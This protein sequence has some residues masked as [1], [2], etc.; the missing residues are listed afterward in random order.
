MYTA[1][2]IIS[3][4][5]VNG[6]GQEHDDPCIIQRG[7]LFNHIDSMQNCPSAAWFNHSHGQYLVDFFSR[8]KLSAFCQDRGRCLL[9]ALNFDAQSFRY[10]ILCHHESLRNCF[11]SKKYIDV[12]YDEY[13]MTSKYAN[14]H[15]TQ[16]TMHQS[17]RQ[18]VNTG[19]D[20]NK[21][22]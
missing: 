1:V 6:V 14:I 4:L 19:R 13:N 8:A 16:M 10:F 9:F 18:K 20:P 15:Y 17:S 7:F 12:P 22:H 21:M 11:L 5:R 3:L 2:L